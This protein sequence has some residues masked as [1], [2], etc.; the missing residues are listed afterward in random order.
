MII[1]GC[2]T[3][4]LDDDGSVDDGGFKWHTQRTGLVV[5]PFMG[6]LKVTPLPH[7]LSEDSFPR[8]ILETD[9]L[10]PAET[11]SDL[12]HLQQ[13]GFSSHGNQLRDMSNYG[14]ALV[15]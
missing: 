9:S 7:L 11:T 10:Y 3:D 12:W 4:S 15:L 14:N 8:D 1:N 5:G 13:E 6:V 2:G